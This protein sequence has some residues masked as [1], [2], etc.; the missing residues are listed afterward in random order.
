VDGAVALW[1]QGY[2]GSKIGV[3]VVD[4]GT[5]KVADF[6]NDN[7]IE[8]DKLKGQRDGRLN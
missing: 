3:A 4:S 1:K 8:Q 2:T 6:S 5:T 7:R